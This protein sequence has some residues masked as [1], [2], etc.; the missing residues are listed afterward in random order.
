M[1]GG[2]WE[3]SNCGCWEDS[4]LGFSQ[5]AEDVSMFIETYIGTISRETF[6]HQKRPIYIK[7]DLS[8]YLYQKRRIHIK[9][10]VF[11]SK[12]SDIG[13]MFKET[14]LYQK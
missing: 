9:R 14:Y 8:I 2:C 1:N 3:D 10:E 4:T 13:T 12:D 7:R 11:I 6:L 5:R